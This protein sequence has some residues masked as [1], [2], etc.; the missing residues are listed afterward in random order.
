MPKIPACRALPCTLA[1]LAAA[2]APT[3]V[4]RGINDPFEAQNRRVHAVNKA[5]D[6]VAFR[7]A[8]RVYGG[9]LPGFVRDGVSNF[10][11][12]VAVPGYLVNDVLQGEIGD[13]GHNFFRFALNTTLGAGGV[14][15]PATSFGLPERESDFGQT[16]YVWGVTEGPYLEVP[17]LGPRTTRD[18]V[19]T[20]V[21]VVANPLRYANLDEAERMVTAAEIADQLDERD[22]FGE[23]IDQVLYESADSYAQARDIY[24]QN[25]RYE[26]GGDQ[27]ED[28]IDPYEDVYGE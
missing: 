16:L 19:G 23:T 10:A 8:S 18:A 28:Y 22:R 4:T 11:E 25:R 13:A 20:V 12:N 24:L 9:V 15:D 6:R 17:L 14:F 26:M 3:E 1:L 21:D 2:C 7:P 5:V 27:T